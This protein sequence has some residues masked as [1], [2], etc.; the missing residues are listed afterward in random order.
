VQAAL[1][2]VGEA[3][4]V[5]YKNIAVFP[6]DWDLTLTETRTISCVVGGIAQTAS[7][8]V[9]GTAKQHVVL[10]DDGNVHEKELEISQP[11]YDFH[12]TGC[13]SFAGCSLTATDAPSG[14]SISKVT[15]R[16]F[17]R[18]LL[19]PVVTYYK[20]GE[21]PLHVHCD[22]NPPFDKDISGIAGQ[23]ETTDTLFIEAKGTD[24]PVTVDASSPG[25]DHKFIWSFKP[26]DDGS[27]P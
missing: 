26:R 23:K 25:D 7:Y 13:G 24:P 3:S 6:K 19:S 27:C 8:H 4:A 10:D 12:P 14:L 20:I 21:P 5:V 2:K 18:S 16:I 15:G 11:N 1:V 9:S 17:N 22:T